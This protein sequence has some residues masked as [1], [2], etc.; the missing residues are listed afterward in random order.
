MLHQIPVSPGYE[1]LLK[2]FEASGRKPFPFQ[3]ET[4]QAYLSGAAKPWLCG[5]P[6]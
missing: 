4:W 3:E 6:A 5:L 2:W 1:L